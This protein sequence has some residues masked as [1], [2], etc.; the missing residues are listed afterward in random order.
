MAQ[1]PTASDRQA[2]KPAQTWP[3]ASAAAAFARLGEALGDHTGEVLERVSTRTNRVCPPLGT[4]ARSGL[5]R[6]CV[7]T[8]AALARWIAGECSE[9]SLTPGGEAWEIL[10]DIA[11]R[12]SAT[13]ADVSERCE[14]WRAAVVEVLAEQ[15]GVLG[16]S[17]EVLAK[18]MS[19][20]NTTLA[21]NLAHVRETFGAE[22]MTVR[23]GVDEHADAGHRGD[24][25]DRAAPSLRGVGASS[26]YLAHERSAGLATGH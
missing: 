10:D 15:A 19:M 4:C 7:L 20:T 11:A 26:R 13:L 21:V 2:I 12:R 3:S 17:P 1:R 9:R 25:N 24:V 5:A 23:C 6:V 18:A 8:T 14:H 16:S 22:T